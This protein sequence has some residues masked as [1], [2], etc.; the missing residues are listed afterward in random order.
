MP[1][2]VAGFYRESL[3]GVISTSTG[4]FRSL[5]SFAFILSASLFVRHRLDAVA[6]VPPAVTVTLYMGIY[7]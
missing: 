2:I 5:R 3:I 6:V 1:P 7:L 4:I